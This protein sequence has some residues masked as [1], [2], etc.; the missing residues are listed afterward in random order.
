MSESNQVAVYYLFCDEAEDRRTQCSIGQTNSLR[1]RFRDHLVHANRR[2]LL[3]NETSTV[4]APRACGLSSSG[5]PPDVAWDATH[6][7]CLAA[8]DSF[9]RAIKR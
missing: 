7:P 1:Q 9:D 8:P 5:V 2:I 6:L 3:H 4:L